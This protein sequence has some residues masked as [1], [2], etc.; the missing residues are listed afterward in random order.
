MLLADCHVHSNCSEDGHYTMAEMLRAETERG[1]SFV[2]FTDHCDFEYYKTGEFDPQHLG[3]W[4]D[5]LSQFDEARHL[6]PDIELRLGLEVGAINHCPEE[7]AI[8]AAIPE[9]DFIIGSVHNNRGIPDFFCLDYDSEGYCYELIDDYLLENLELAQIGHFD[10]LGHL[11]YTLR[12]MN[13][14][15]HK[16]KITLERHGDVLDAIFKALISSGRGLEINCSGFREPGFSE[17]YPT[18]SLLKRYR[19][20]GGAIITIGTDAH[21][22]E[23]AG[24]DLERGLAALTEAGFEYYTVFRERKPS[25]VKID[26][27]TL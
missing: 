25:F 11:G 22:T 5:I 3:R 12:Y 19:E 26:G 21:V 9:L 20:L 6:F 23:H 2:C 18:V 13:R 16:P 4:D 24:L 7:G 14:A 15:G 27:G 10:V 8:V 1:V 17:S